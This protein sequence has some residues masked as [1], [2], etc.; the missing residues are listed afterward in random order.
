L[1][2]VGQG[3][4]L[5]TPK[6]GDVQVDVLS[7]LAVLLSDRSN[8]PVSWWKRRSLPNLTRRIACIPSHFLH[9]YPHWH[10]VVPVTGWSIR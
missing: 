6:T 8:P 5:Y 10:A 9:A 3:G 4:C 7:G 1:Y 2:V